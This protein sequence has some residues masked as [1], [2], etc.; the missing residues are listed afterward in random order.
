MSEL[1]LVPRSMSIWVR[2]DGLCHIEGSIA[3]DAGLGEGGTEQ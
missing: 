3:P 1:R 2:P